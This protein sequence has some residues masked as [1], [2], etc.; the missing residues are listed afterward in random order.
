MFHF[1]F[2]D[3]NYDIETKDKRQRSLSS[4]ILLYSVNCLNKGFNVFIAS[5]P[6]E[7]IPNPWYRMS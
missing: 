7:L 4:L 5:F 1:G 2:I 3:E 6:N